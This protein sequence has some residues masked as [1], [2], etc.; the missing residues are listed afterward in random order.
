MRQKYFECKPRGSLEKEDSPC[1]WGLCQNRYSDN[2]NRKGVIE[3]IEA[4]NELPA[5]CFQCRPGC[6]CVCVPAGTLFFSFR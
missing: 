4:A 6:G 1:N 3:E 5:S 2:E